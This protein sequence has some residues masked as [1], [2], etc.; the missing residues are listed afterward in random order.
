[1]IIQMEQGSELQ[2]FEATDMQADK[3][4]NSCFVF[5]KND[6][7]SILVNLHVCK[8]SK[9]ILLTSLD[10]HFVSNCSQIKTRWQTAFLFSVQRTH[11]PVTRPSGSLAFRPSLNATAAELFCSGKKMTNLNSLLLF[12]SFYSPAWIYFFVNALA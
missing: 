12:F 11:L 10:D 2:P 9:P 7:R 5:F 6:F 3:K 4:S 8:T 1:M